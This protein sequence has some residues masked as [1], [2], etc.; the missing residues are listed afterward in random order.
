MVWFHIF[1]KELLT[2]NCIRAAIIKWVIRTFYFNH[3]YE[4]L[5]Q[6]YKS[7]PI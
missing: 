3:L 2:V 6:R 5:F 7:L 1:E 4:I